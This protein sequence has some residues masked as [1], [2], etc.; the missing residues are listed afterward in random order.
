MTATCLKHLPAHPVA[1]VSAALCADAGLGNGAQPAAPGARSGTADGDVKLQRSSPGETLSHS[2]GVTDQPGLNRCRAR[3]TQLVC[4]ATFAP[5]A[6]RPAGHHDQDGLAHR[7]CPGGSLLP[8]KF[9]GFHHQL[10]A[11]AIAF[12]NDRH[13]LADAAPVDRQL[14][15]GRVLNLGAVH[16]TD[17]IAGAD[18]S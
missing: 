12:H 10:D 1:K 18:S 2:Q 4:E 6:G 16:F 7:I 15:L 9:L 5:P 11:V 8:R 14:H 17:Q 13:G 3:L